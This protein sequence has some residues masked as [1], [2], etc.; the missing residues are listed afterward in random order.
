ML[1]CIEIASA[2]KKETCCVCSVNEESCFF[3]HE[4]F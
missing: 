1:A 4:S 2:A 3:N